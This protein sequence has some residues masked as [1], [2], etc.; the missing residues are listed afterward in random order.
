MNANRRTALE[1]AVKIAPSGTA[2]YLVTVLARAM[3]AY[4]GDEEF[5]ARVAAIEAAVASSAQGT[6]A[7]DLLKTAREFED[8]LA[9]VNHD[10]DQ[11][12]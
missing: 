10:F 6:D 1:C 9:G 3:L 5:P 7:P 2:P 11:D 4:L 12:S 8:F